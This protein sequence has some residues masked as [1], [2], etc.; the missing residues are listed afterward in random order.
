MSQYDGLTKM[1]GQ[2]RDEVYAGFGEK[3]P[4]GW[5]WT[6]SP[7]AGWRPERVPEEFWGVI[8]MC[9]PR[10]KHWVVGAPAGADDVDIY[11]GGDLAITVA[12]KGAGELAKRLAAYLNG[13]DPYHLVVHAIADA[14]TNNP[15]QNLLPH[16][17]ECRRLA[18][19]TR[20]RIA[21]YG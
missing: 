1:S 9:R 3:V 7:T 8:V 18:N 16:L 19:E 5:E 15:G 4:Q 13:E 11:A 17:Q 21:S 6:N 12:T 14:Q 20:A 10:K 2:G